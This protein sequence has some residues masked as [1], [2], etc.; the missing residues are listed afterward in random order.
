MNPVLVSQFDAVVA[1]LGVGGGEVAGDVHR[2]RGGDGG[3]EYG[4]AGKEIRGAFEGVGSVGFTWPGDQK[5]GCA[6]LGLHKQI[7]DICSSQRS[8]RACSCSNSKTTSSGKRSPFQ[9]LTF[10]QLSGSFTGLSP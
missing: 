9:P 7:R 1:G 6:G 2:G 4:E 8:I 3:L 5:A 10:D